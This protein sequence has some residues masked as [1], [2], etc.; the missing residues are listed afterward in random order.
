MEE[1]NI[2]KKEKI[3]KLESIKNLIFQEK[4]EIISL[5][6]ALGHFLALLGKQLGIFQKK[7]EII[8]ETD[9]LKQKKLNLLSYKKKLTPNLFN[10]KNR[11]KVIE[12]YQ[13]RINKEIQIINSH[14]NQLV[15]LAHIEK[16]HFMN[17][18]NDLMILTNK[19]L[20]IFQECE[21]DVNDLLKDIEVLIIE[22]K[23]KKTFYLSSSNDLIN[24]IPNKSLIYSPT[25]HF[26]KL[27]YKIVDNSQIK[28]DI[29]FLEKSNFNELT[30]ETLNFCCNINNA[31]LLFVPELH[32][33]NI[34]GVK[35]IKEGI[36]LVNDNNSPNFN[37]ENDSFYPSVEIEFKNSNAKLQN[38]FF[39]FFEDYSKFIKEANDV[40]SKNDI[41][42]DKKNFKNYLNSVFEIREI[43]LLRD[44]FFKSDLFNKL[45]IKYSRNP[46]NGDYIYCDNSNTLSFLY[47]S[48]AN[49]VYF[50]ICVKK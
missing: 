9:L 36:V 40:S 44:Y 46:E 20:T 28:G 42:L 17:R 1:D 21:N 5:K 32:L 4:N 14:L 13:T 49:N 31:K 35:K 41:R 39:K 18:V 33:K 15:E 27:E 6:T 7:R 11:L 45:K 43:D 38:Y 10:S 37:Y 29:N 34:N 24:I 50:L 3:E 16:D 12:D 22:L 47:F 26:F 25:K 2:K 19:I 48:D 23:S 8:L 30:F